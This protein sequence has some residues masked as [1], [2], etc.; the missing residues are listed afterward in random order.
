MVAFT[1]T[2]FSYTFSTMDHDFDPPEPPEGPASDG[3]GVIHGTPPRLLSR[4]SA[5]FTV[6]GCRRSGSWVLDDSGAETSDADE[7]DADTPS[8]SVSPC[9]R[10]DSETEE[11]VEEIV[12]VKSTSTESADTVATA[13]PAAT[14]APAAATAT[15]AA[16][17]A[18]ATATPA[19]APAAATAAPTA[20]PTA[21][22]ATPAAATVL[23]ASADTVAPQHQKPTTQ[24]QTR[25]TK[26]QA[27]K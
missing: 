20:A 19:A 1:I 16:T 13:T 14:A 26:Q 18:A 11:R 3:E 6:T 9:E 23:C 8:D 10:G 17:P 27:S 7:S 21:A 25:A 2:F 22:T 15:P 12:M 24:R 5:A 4:R